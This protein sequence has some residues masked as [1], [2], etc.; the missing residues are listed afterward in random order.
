MPFE[1]LYPEIKFPVSRGTPMLSPLVKW[2]HT[3]D[4][5]VTKFEL[6]RTSYSWERKVK[7]SLKDHDYDTIEGHIIDGTKRNMCMLFTI[8]L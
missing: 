1:K 7:V 3:E 5:F 4:W 2:E 8:L 6:Q